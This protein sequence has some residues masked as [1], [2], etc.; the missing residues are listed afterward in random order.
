MLHADSSFKSSFNG[1]AGLSR[2]TLIDGYNVT[3]TSIGYRSGTGWE[4]AVF[5]RNLLGANYIQ[6]VTV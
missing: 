4:V 1:D 3:N 5:A 6:N 2:F